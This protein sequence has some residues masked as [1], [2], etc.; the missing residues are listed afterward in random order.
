[1]EA[2]AYVVAATY[3]VR[4]GEEDAVRGVLQE[5]APLSRSEPGCIY[6]LVH[7]DREQGTLFLYEQY[8]DEGAY[9][10]HTRTPHFERLIKQEAL[11]RLEDRQRSF[12]ITLEEDARHAEVPQAGLAVAAR[13]RARSGDEDAL[14]DGLFE[15][16][17]AM[18]RA[19]GCRLCQLQRSVEDERGFLVY[20]QFADEAAYTALAG[21]TFAGDVKHRVHE[22]IESVQTSV[23]LPLA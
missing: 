16:A 3:R 8:E 4:K 14:S 15:L 18:R 2:M 22:H 6:Y 21:E 17:T 1:M 7:R 10:E 5:M 23:Y 11:P 9:Q 19:P 20:E 13:L 12:Y